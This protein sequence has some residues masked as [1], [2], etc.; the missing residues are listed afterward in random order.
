[1]ARGDRPGDGTAADGS[2]VSEGGVAVRMGLDDATTVRLKSS[3]STWRLSV[4]QRLT[5]VDVVTLLYV[6]VATAAVLAFLRLRPRQLGPAAHGTRAARDVG[7]P[8]APRPAG[9]PL[10]SLPGRLVPDAAARRA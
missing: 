2:L 6:A 7:A 9:R 1:M 8:R 3:L 5:A 4:L 10:R